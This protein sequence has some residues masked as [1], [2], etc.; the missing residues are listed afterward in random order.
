VEPEAERVAE[1][2]RRLLEDRKEASRLAEN[3]Y[4]RVVEEYSWDA[5]A[6][7]YLRLYERLL[8][9]EA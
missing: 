1:A 9:G 3:A 6:P 7:R 8:E 2:V 4:R 5:V